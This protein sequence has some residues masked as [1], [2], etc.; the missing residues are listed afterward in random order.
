MTA[1]RLIRL[2]CSIAGRAARTRGPRLYRLVIDCQDRFDAVEHRFKLDAKRITLR[3]TKAARAQL[4]ELGYD[5]AFGARPL[6][7]TML[8]QLQDPLAEA[9]LRGGYGPGTTI[10]VDWVDGAFKFDSDDA[11]EQP[12]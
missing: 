8:R 4:V 6:K 10:T 12:A 7:R 2:L 11:S 5:P 3:L 1:A 9:L